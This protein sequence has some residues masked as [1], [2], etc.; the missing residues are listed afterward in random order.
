M[1]P[2]KFKAGDW[3]RNTDIGETLGEFTRY[4]KPHGGLP[5][6]EVRIGN[7]IHI[8]REYLLREPEPVPHEQRYISQPV[9]AD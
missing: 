3:V 9:D 4:V 6:C 5:M 1:I 2:T 8:C 7:V